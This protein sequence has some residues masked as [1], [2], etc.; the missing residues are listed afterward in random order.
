MKW[1]V[2]HQMNAISLFTFLYCSTLFVIVLAKHHDQLRYLRLTSEIVQPARLIGLWR[3]PRLS[4]RHFNVAGGVLLM[5]FACA[6]LGIATRLWLLVAV[7]DYFLYFGQIRT[8]A[9]VVRKSN[10]IPQFLIV[11]VLA[12]SDSAMSAR[13]GCPCWP[14]TI[15]KLLVVQVYLSGA[16]CKLRNSG[17]R[18]SSGAQLQ[19]ILM[20]Q[21]MLFDLPW[22]SKLAGKRKLCSAFAGLVLFHQL[23]FPL[24]FVFRGTEIF[25]VGFAL[26][27]HLA[28]LILMRINYLTYQGPSYII[29]VV[30]PLSR[31]IFGH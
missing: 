26:L 17:F 21:H 30:V 7:V 10:L 28:S 24:I 1:P 3:V 6:A 9:Y 18:W 31:V 13:H 4:P 19:G 29:F 14:V 5:C 2:D 11:L 23:T 16:F 8:L 25:Y 15:L 12:H 22:A 27:F 20:H